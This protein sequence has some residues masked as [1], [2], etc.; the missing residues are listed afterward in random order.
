MRNKLFVKSVCAVGVAALCL[1]GLAACSSSEDGYTGGVAATV[2]GTEIKED[3]ITQ[4]IENERDQYIYYYSLMGMDFSDTDDENQLW[5]EYLDARDMTPEELREECID[6]YIDNEILSQYAGER[7]VE[8]SDEEVDEYVTSMRDNY[9]SEEDWKDALDELGI[10]EDDYKE[11]IDHQLLYKAVLETFSDEDEEEG[12]DETTDDEATDESDDEATDEEMLAY[13]QANAK[14][15][16]DGAKRSSHV[17]FDSDDKDQA[18]EVLDQIKS[19]D[20]TVAEAAEQYSTDTGSA[21]DGGDVGWDVLTTFVTEYQDALD[22][23]DKGQV[24]DLV[25]SEY[26]YHIIE[27]TDV[28]NVP[29]DI[30]SISDWPSAIVDDIRDKVTGEDD[31]ESDEAQTEAYDAWI[32]ECRDEADIEINDMPEDVPYNV[33]VS[34]YISDD[35]GEEGDGTEADSDADKDTEADSDTNADDKADSDSDS[36]SSSDASSDTEKDS[37]TTT[38]TG[39]SNDTDKEND[40]S[41]SSGSGG[42]SN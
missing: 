12:D 42:A 22:E 38:D 29:D 6:E 3:D 34:E 26:G 41:S 31:S 15:D 7:G 36:D 33:D 1:G 37:G 18:K 21:T 19:G 30:T 11:S 17:L 16:Y 35:E 40:T 24:S 39:S 23:L 14:A 2:N 13:A 5:A 28:F 9:A 20:L 32:E 25:E 8:V 4:A 10:T 27:C